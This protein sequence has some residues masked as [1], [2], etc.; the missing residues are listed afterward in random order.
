MHE[1]GESKMSGTINY[2][3]QNE[4]PASIQHKFPLFAASF[5]CK[6]TNFSQVYGGFSQV[7]RPM[8]FKDIVPN[9]IYEKVDENIKDAKGYNA[10]LRFRG[11]WKSLKVGRYRFFTS[12][13]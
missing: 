5:S 10:E 2:Y 6:P 1:I 8:L 13:Q 7:Y 12:I 4:I 11:N 3:P 9:S